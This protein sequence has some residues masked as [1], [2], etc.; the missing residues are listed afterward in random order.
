MN[1]GG[2]GLTPTHRH[3]QP[4][5]NGLL[6]R[7]DPG[8]RQGQTR[9]YNL[10]AKCYGREADLISEAP[11]HWRHVAIGVAAVRRF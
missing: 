11:Q 2:G 6:A 1:W 10:E 7:L 3:F 9:T 5:C 4:W 8:E